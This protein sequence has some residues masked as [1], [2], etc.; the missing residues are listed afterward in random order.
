M[1]PAMIASSNVMLEKWRDHKGKEI[2]VYEEFKI[3]TSDVI[4]RT[5]FRSRY[6]DG[7]A[8]FDMLEQLNLIAGKNLYKLRLPGIR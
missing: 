6:E 8:I 1:I 7:K 4:S 5:A 3:M 2:E